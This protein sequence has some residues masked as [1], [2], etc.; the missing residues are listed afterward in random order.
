MFPF[1]D[2]PY[3]CFSSFRP[4]PFHCVRHPHPLDPDRVYGLGSFPSNRQ[5]ASLFEILVCAIPG[6]I[7]FSNFILSCLYR[8]LEVQFANEQYLIGV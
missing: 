4:Y 7:F 8:L 3:S 5:M 6:N 1:T 2:L